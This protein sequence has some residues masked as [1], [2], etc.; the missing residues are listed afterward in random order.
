MIVVDTN[1]ISYLLIPNDTYNPLAEAIY[2]KDSRWS[3]PLLWRYEFMSV[4]SIYL[5]KDL[6]DVAS[7][8]S[9]YKEAMDLVISGPISNSDA[10]FNIVQQSSL[11]SYDF[12]FVAL[13]MQTGLPL[14]TE[15]KK[16][17]REFPDVAFSM[18]TYVSI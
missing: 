15:D 7:C 14:I 3:S 6:M 13:A 5:R 16:I 1:I 10:V 12:E 8:K 11:S 2:Q 4:L 9:V 18:K 17:L